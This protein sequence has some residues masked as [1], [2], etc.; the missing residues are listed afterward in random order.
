MLGYYVK[1][2][3]RRALA[4][5]LFDVD[6]RLRADAKRRSVVAPPQRSDSA[7]RKESSKRTAA[8]MAQDWQLCVVG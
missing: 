6:D 7:M 8:A 3:M 2:H 5:M 1:R 4:P